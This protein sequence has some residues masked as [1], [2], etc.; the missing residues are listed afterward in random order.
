MPYAL[1]PREHLMLRSKG[2]TIITKSG[3]PFFQKFNFLD[4]LTLDFDINF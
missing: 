1:S 3:F 2:Y 4:F